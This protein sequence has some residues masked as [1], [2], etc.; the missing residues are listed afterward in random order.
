MELTKKKQ[1]RQQAI[2]H[3]LRRQRAA[4]HALSLLTRSQ[5]RRNRKR[6]RRKPSSKHP[7]AGSL[8]SWHGD[9]VKVLLLSHGSDYASL[10]ATLAECLRTVKVDAIA[11]IRRHFRLKP[12]TELPLLYSPEAIEEMAGKADVI[13][14]MHS[15]L[16]PQLERIVKDKKC[17]VFH[18]GT[19]YRTLYKHINERFNKKVHLS[20]VQTGELLGRGAKNERWFLPPVDTKKILPDYSFAR[21]DKLVVGHFSSHLGRGSR[22]KGSPLIG[23]VI[24]SLARSELGERFIFK[25]HGKELLPWKDNLKR[26]AGCDIYIE[27]LSQGTTG[28][29]RHD[30]SITALEA[31]ALGCITVTNFL[32]EKRYLKEYGEHELIVAN[33][34]DELETA[35]IRLLSMSREEL[36]AL[37]HKARQWVEEMHNYKIVGKRLKTILGI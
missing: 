18:G 12:E 20:L 5:L 30:W 32:S 14:W 11:V 36:L 1:R 8:A 23:T 37:K 28:K 10:T 15:V 19:R 21:N 33:T 3:R 9:T 24:N 4:D 27:S 25:T 26:M 22:T 7:F 6:L 34:S 16:Y 2:K 29:N 13:I 35:L 31:C 17:V